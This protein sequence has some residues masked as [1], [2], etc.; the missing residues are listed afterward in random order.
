MMPGG[1][2][3]PV[4]L[5]SIEPAE[6]GERHLISAPAQAK[7]IRFELSFAYGAEKLLPMPGK[8]GMA[9]VEEYILVLRTES[10]G[11]SL[12]GT[13]SS[14]EEGLAFVERHHGSASSYTGARKHEDQGSALCA[15]YPHG[16]VEPFAFVT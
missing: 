7:D 14:K 4:L 15:T 8:V 1:D 12:S 16:P 6:S 10:P 13:S 9:F 2:H 5:L 3:H 11:E